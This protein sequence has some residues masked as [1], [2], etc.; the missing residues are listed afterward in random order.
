MRWK[1]VNNFLFYG[2]GVLIV[3]F[4][5]EWGRGMLLHVQKYVLFRCMFGVVIFKVY[6]C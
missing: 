1:I 4:K 6:P 5:L 3:N 2:R